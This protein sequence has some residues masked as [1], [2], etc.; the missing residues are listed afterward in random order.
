MVPGQ[1]CEAEP[2]VA[3]CSFDEPL[4]ESAV[5]WAAEQA[6]TISARPSPYMLFTKSIQVGTNFRA[7]V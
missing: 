4:V 1:A 3:V 7:R 6:G 2:P 5:V